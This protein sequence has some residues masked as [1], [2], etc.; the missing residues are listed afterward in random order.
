[1]LWRCH[2]YEYRACRSKGGALCIESFATLP[3]ITPDK[4]KLLMCSCLVALS[5]T[6]HEHINNFL[7][8]GVILGS[9][10]NDS[11]HRAPP[12]LRQARYSYRWQRQSMLCRRSE[13]RRVGKEC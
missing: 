7:L 10:A 4:R 12:L 1:M 2:R 3:R 13:E 5:A 6:R 8:S 9:V 11:M